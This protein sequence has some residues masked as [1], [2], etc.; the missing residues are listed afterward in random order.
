[1]AYDGRVG[2]VCVQVRDDERTERFVVC[3]SASAAN[4][5]PGE[6]APQDTR[7]SGLVEELEAREE[8]RKMGLDEAHIESHIQ[9]ARTF[10]TTTTSETLFEDWVRSLPR[11]ES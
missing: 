10:K 2:V 8:L 5:V 1:M 6:S 7:C 4:W 9:R 11:K 3:S